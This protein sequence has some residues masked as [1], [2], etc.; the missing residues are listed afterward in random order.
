MTWLVVLAWYDSAVAFD[1]IQNVVV[2]R[3]GYMGS[4]TE[5]ATIK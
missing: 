4:S 2:M 3:I 1:G 5:I